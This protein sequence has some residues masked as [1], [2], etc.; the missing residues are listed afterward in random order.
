MRFLA[1]LS[2]FCCFIGCQTNPPT[3]FKNED[4][5]NL[6]PL[7]PGNSWTLSSYGESLPGTYTMTVVGDT[8]FDGIEYSVIR[9]TRQDT[10]QTYTYFA[11]T[12]SSNR[13]W[14]VEGGRRLFILD[15]TEQEY[16]YSGY[17]IKVTHPYRLE[18][19]AGIFLHGANFYIDHP[20]IADEETGYIFFPGVGLISMYGAWGFDYRLVS[21]EL[22]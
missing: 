6:F 15:P 19:H 1:V 10:D 18:T 2:L 12:D 20:Q 4:P 13:I 14:L 5:K 7:A 11:R 8:I 22:K 21:Y 9:Q 17:I 16:E 3:V